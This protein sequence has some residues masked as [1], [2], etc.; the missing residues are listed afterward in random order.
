MT[1]LFAHVASEPQS[2]L[3]IAIF[4]FAAG[5]FPIGLML[6]APCSKCCGL[7]SACT[8]GKL[9]DTI[10]V[11][12]DGLPNSTQEQQDHYLCMVTFSSPCFG[13]GGSARPLAPGGVRG[14]DEGPITSITLLDGGSGYAVLGRVEPLAT[15]AVEEWGEP[16][17]DGGVVLDPVWSATIDDCGLTTWSLESVT[18][19]DAGQRVPQGTAVVITPAEGDTQAS[20]A[21]ATLVLSVSAPE[22][23]ASVSGGSEASLSVVLDGNSVTSVTIDNA[24]SGYTNNAQVVFSYAPDDY[25]DE[26]PVAFITTDGN[27]SITAVTVT[28]QGNVYKSV[29]SSVTVDA[30]GTYYRE[31]AEESAVVAPVTATLTQAAW[32]T[33][34]G[35]EFSV[36]VD[37]APASET[38]GE[39][40]AVE[41]DNGGD[42]YLCWIYKQLCC[43]DHYDGKSF[44]LK[45][46]HPGAGPLTGNPKCAFTHF[47]CGIGDAIPKSDQAFAQQPERAELN[48]L[49]N[50]PNSPPTVELR[51]P[52]SGCNVSFVSDSLVSD[53]DN[54]SF[55]AYG[56]N[57][58]TA[59]VS[60]GGGY[61]NTAG[62]GRPGSCHVCC[63]GDDDIA[64]EVETTIT[65]WYEE[66]GETRVEVTAD[67]TLLND[68]LATDPALSFEYQYGEE[69]LVP[70]RLPRWS[71]PG[72][73][74]LGAGTAYEGEPSE[75]WKAVAPQFLDAQQNGKPSDPGGFCG[76][77]GPAIS[78]AINIYTWDE[79]LVGTTFP[80]EFGTETWRSW[81]L[82][83]FAVEIGPCDT[84]VGSSWSGSVN[85]FPGTTMQECADC[86]KTCWTKAT[87]SDAFGG[88]ALDINPTCDQCQETPMC[89][90]SAGVYETQCR[91]AGGNSYPGAAGVIVEVHSA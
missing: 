28:A 79:S 81:P 18:V 16:P 25:V 19:T 80:I 1:D 7:C 24:G 21:S 33:G 5:M 69:P 46:Q 76:I 38:F 84:Q 75:F 67:V 59:T 10:T 64:E 47:F 91:E 54:F 3:A 61:D 26:V 85:L 88:V 78:A 14:V 17:E 83:G 42:G 11:A 63:R 35:A 68:V 12:L 9:P 4:L 49:Y 82:P 86:H 52:F 40:T 44:V 74:P 57:G 29:V 32:G 56:P 45:R 60:S 48:V 22:I 36:T 2:A 34:D 53:C 31:D 72:Q 41:I 58:E 73:L 70:F 13:A 20:A 50:G 15:V 37:D 39:I 51:E 77:E 27:G 43:G 8:S 66:E 55:T 23:T 30:G 71:F 89:G 6:G 65:W 62:L 90:P 87:L